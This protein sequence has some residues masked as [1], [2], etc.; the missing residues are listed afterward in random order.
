MELAPQKTEAVMPRGAKAE[1][2]ISFTC[3]GVEILFQKSLVYLGITI[4][5]NCS[6]GNH[7]KIVTQKAGEKAGVLNRITLNIKGPGSTK[8]EMLYNVAQLIFWNDYM[9]N[10]KY[11]RQATK[12]QRKILIRVTSAYRNV[13]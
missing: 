2:G 3:G 11:K 5:K 13:A 10:E 9:R 12:V 8:R 6:F 1:N 4:G 7:I